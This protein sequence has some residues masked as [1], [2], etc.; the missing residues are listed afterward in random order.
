MLWRRSEHDL[1]LR[2]TCLI[3][4]GDANTHNAPVADA[5][6]SGVPVIKHDCVGH[7]QENGH[8]TAQV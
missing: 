6:C 2:Y 1:R 4:D 8:L 5:S 7:V 3:A